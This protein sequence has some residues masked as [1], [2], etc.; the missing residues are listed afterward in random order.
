MINLEDYLKEEDY[1]QVYSSVDEIAYRKKF[2]YRLIDY[3]VGVFMVSIFSINE[4]NIECDLK[5]KQKL[6]RVQILYR[7]KFPF[8]LNGEYSDRSPPII[9]KKFKNERELKEYLDNLTSN[10][11]YE[12]MYE[13]GK[14]RLEYEIA[15]SYLFERPTLQALN[16]TIKRL[17]PINRDK[18]EYDYVDFLSSDQVDQTTLKK[19]VFKKTFP[20]SLIQKMIEK[21]KISKLFFVAKVMGIM[22]YRILDRL[23]G[24]KY[25]SYYQT[26]FRILDIEEAIKNNIVI[27][28]SNDVLLKNCRFIE[29]L[30]DEYDNEASRRILRK[31]KDLGTFKIDGEDFFI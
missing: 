7:I 25:E 31:M 1:N 28:I 11:N 30:C 20:T 8:F 24:T 2:Q 29:E 10:E 4:E 12:E 22:D 23:R 9:M 21:L 27:E 5:T 15:K 18:I 16:A 26:E 3:D 13:K 19:L 17:N 6:Y 14:N